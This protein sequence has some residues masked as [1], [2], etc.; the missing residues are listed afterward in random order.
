MAGNPVTRE[1]VARWLLDKATA[2]LARSRACVALVK[3][4]R[5]QRADMRAHYSKLDHAALEVAIDVLLAEHQ[6][7]CMTALACM[8]QVEA[9]AIERTGRS[10]L[11]RRA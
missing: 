8:D 1:S 7:S 3:E 4:I 9:V 10:P 6:R 5:S 2:S 11:R